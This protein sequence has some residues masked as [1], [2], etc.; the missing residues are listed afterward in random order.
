M[1]VTGQASAITCRNEPSPLSS[2]D[3]TVAGSGSS[4]AGSSVGSG[5][6]SGVSAGTA[7]LAAVIA[8]VRLRHVA[9]I[10]AAEETAVKET[11]D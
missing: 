3:V 7:A 11:T 1:V 5:S 4:S 10:G 6:G 2:S 9:P 8:A